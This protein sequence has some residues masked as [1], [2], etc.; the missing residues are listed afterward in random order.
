MR[1]MYAAIRILGSLERDRITQ[2]LKQLSPDDRR[3]RFG[4]DLDDTAIEHHVAAINFARDKLLGVFEESGELVAVA[5]L[6]LEAQRDSA[7]LGISVAAGCRCFGYGYALLCA[8]APYARR[9]GRRRLTM[10]CLA[11]NRVMTHLARKAGMSVI[12]ELG[13]AGTYVALGGVAQTPPLDSPRPVAGRKARAVLLGVL[14]PIFGMDMALLVA[15]G[16]A[17]DSCKPQLA[18]ARR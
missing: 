1:A 12:S 13:E 8:A 16:A 9:A 18:V 15:A 5:H 7:G 17:C 3:L 10:H 14:L 11:E 2:H 4:A 6:A